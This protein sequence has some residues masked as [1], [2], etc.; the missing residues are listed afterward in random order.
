MLCFPIVVPLRGAYRA[1]SQQPSF[2]STADGAEPPVDL[3]HLRSAAFWELQ[4]S[5]AENG[6]GLV[7]RMRDWEEAHAQ[8]F[9]KPEEGYALGPMRRPFVDSAN[10]ASFD[11]DE[12]EVQIIEAGGSFHCDLFSPS[13]SLLSNAAA[14]HMGMDLENQGSSVGTSFFSPVDASPC[15]SSSSDEDT[16]GP[17]TLVGSSNSPRASL[18][19]RSGSISKLATPSVPLASPS[20]KA[21]AA[22]TL[23][24]ANGAGSLNDYGAVRSLEAPHVASLDDPLVGEMWH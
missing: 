17:L 3:T 21:I 4:R 24:M 6:E 9:S 11:E 20:E 19:L 1:L 15:L 10:G 8:S 2:A 5:I 13:L 18:P 23:V 12:D 7:T 14:D 16:P 22:L